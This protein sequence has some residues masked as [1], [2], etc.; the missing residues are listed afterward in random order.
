[1]A[2]AGGRAHVRQP[3][4]DS[5]GNQVGVSSNAEDAA[6]QGTSRLAVARHQLVWQLYVASQVSQSAAPEQGRQGVFITNMSSM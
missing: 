4:D 3:S 5:G 2:K 6:Q 1:M